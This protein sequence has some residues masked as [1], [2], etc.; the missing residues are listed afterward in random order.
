MSH[1]LVYMT[2]AICCSHVALSLKHFF[3]SIHV[4]LHLRA[5]SEGEMVTCVY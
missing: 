5:L 4:D 3:I 2:V 1:I